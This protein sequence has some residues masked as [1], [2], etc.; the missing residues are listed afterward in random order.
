MHSFY[1]ALGLD[2]SASESDIRFAYRRRALATHPDKGGTAESFRLV[3][4][5]FETLIDSARRAAYDRRHLVQ[6]HGRVKLQA[7][8]TGS[9]APRS[10]TTSFSCHEKAVRTSMRYP[11]R[12]LDQSSQAQSR[13]VNKATKKPRE[14]SSSPANACSKDNLSSKTHS[15]SAESEPDNSSALLLLREL[16]QLSKSDCKARLAN[17][18]LALLEELAALLEAGAAAASNHGLGTERVEQSSDAVV[19]AS[20]MSS[21][22]EASDP[23][24]FLEDESEAESSVDPEPLLAIRDAAPEKGRESAAA[25]PSATGRT[26]GVF[27][28][29]RKGTYIASVGIKGLLVST[30]WVSSLDLAIDMHISLIR[31]RQLVQA[32]ILPDGSFRQALSRSLEAVIR[33][34]EHAASPSIR[35]HYEVR[36]RR[37]NMKKCTVDFDKAMS[38]WEDLEQERGRRAAQKQARLDA[39]RENRAELA[40]ER[41][42]RR[43]EKRQAQEEKLR[44]RA[45]IRRQRELRRQG[46]QLRAKEQLHRLHEKATEHRNWLKVQVR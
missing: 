2:P 41:K 21:E 40:Q 27:L 37:K 30:Q 26:R 7:A 14:S 29:K 25:K 19:A 32:D 8:A 18:R 42:C 36:S 10:S 46:R 6:R 5:A 31:L 17:S 1:E 44:L 20:G 35:F 4:E 23:Q 11:K 43:E 13:T 15:S 3:V 45:E 28:N 9:S 34:R 16:L 33:E 24:G 12:R 22:T 38:L 39:D